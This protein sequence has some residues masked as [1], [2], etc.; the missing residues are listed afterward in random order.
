MTANPLT[1]HPS[2]TVE[3]DI[4][5]A[6]DSV[7][8]VPGITRPRF[9]AEDE[10][11]DAILP[12]HTTRDYHMELDA[13]DQ[14]AMLD[15]DPWEQM[16][17]ETDHQ[18]NMFRHFLHS[19]YT[20]TRRATADE[21]GVGRKRADGLARDNQWERRVRA[22]DLERERIYAGERI[23]KVR[24]MADRHAAVIQRG[25]E[26]MAIA[27]HPLVKR[28]AEDPEGF[29]EEVGELS[30]KSQFSLAIQAARV[31]PALMG[32]ERLAND[33]PTEISAVHA[34][35][36]GEVTIHS[37]DD[38]ANL[39]GALAGINNLN[40]IDAEPIE[41]VDTRPHQLDDGRGDRGVEAEADPAE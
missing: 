17:G 31:L 5:W 18:F 9:P 12:T 41:P 27:F 1:A 35:V 8:R 16:P 30:I 11:S 19:G 36:T 24:E 26:A 33:M 13:D 29:A 40:I 20:R 10:L 23:D 34:D 37:R 28:A 39:V 32:A 3:D 6:L 4:E 15:L 14:G 21:F 22:W 2:W 38:L 7:E 25:I